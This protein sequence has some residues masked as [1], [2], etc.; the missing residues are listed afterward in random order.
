MG[1]PRDFIPCFIENLTNTHRTLS[2]LPV[3]LILFILAQ[4]GVFRLVGGDLMV[5]GYNIEKGT[6]TPEAADLKA[7]AKLSQGQDQQAWWMLANADWHDSALL[8]YF[9][10]GP[11]GAEEMDKLA[12]SSGNSVDQ[13]WVAS[14]IKNVTWPIDLTDLLQRLAISHH[15]MS[16]SVKGTGKIKASMWTIFFRCTI[17]SAIARTDSSCNEGYMVPL[18]LTHAASAHVE[19][20]NL[21]PVGEPVSPQPADVN[22]DKEERFA[23]HTVWLP[24]N[25]TLLVNA[26]PSSLLE[27]A[28][29]S[30]QRIPAAATTIDADSYLSIAINIHDNLPLCP[31]AAILSYRSLLDASYG[32][33]PGFSCILF[34]P[35]STQIAG[36][37]ADFTLLINLN[38]PPNN[39][40]ATNADDSLLHTAER[41]LHALN[42]TSGYWERKPIKDCSKEAVL[43]HSVA[44][45]APENIVLCYEG[46]CVEGD[47]STVNCTAYVENEQGRRFV[48]I[49]HLG[50]L[51]LIVRLSNA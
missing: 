44:D 18:I 7:V 31:P 51:R 19:A 13:S 17:A 27:S 49:Q 48:Y 50:F 12:S 37:L 39:V 3:R 2:A 33:T 29:I 5:D 35:P 40:T 30:Q 21:L 41:L 15:W 4:N 20:S 14:R 8:R 26:L 24:L 32:L 43:K 47:L 10:A 6:L 34:R 42:M 45:V 23:Y 16:E 46:I 36:F 38:L 28:K 22:E 1:R 9:K 25:P 11:L